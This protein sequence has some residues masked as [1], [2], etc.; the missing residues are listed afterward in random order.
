MKASN[1][2]A[3]ILATIHICVVFAF[4]VWIYAAYRFGEGESPMYWIFMYFVDFPV[5]LLLKPLCFL[6]EDFPNVSWL[7][8]LAGN[9]P[10]F[11]YPLVFFSIIGTVWWYSVGW[12]CGRGWEM[13]FRRSH[14]KSI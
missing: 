5:T 2:F 13:I 14:D 3:M 6:V 10:N 1:K 7:P 8:G 12:V 4:S 11:L 9:W